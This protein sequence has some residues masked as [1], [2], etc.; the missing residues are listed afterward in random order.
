MPGIEARAYQDFQ[1][2]SFKPLD[3]V[4]QMPGF[5]KE[6]FN[7]QLRNG[8]D[9]YLAG[10]QEKSKE[11][12]AYELEQDAVLYRVLAKEKG[13]EA[14][15]EAKNGLDAY[16]KMQLETHLGERLNVGIS[17][18]T[19]RIVDGELRTEDTNEPVL[20]M[21]DRGRKYRRK[22]GKAVDWDR[23][24]AEVQGLSRIQATLTR[25][26]EEVAPGTMMLFAS[27]QGD[28][29]N[30]SIYKQD[31]Y[32]LQQKMEDGTV[33]AHRFTSGL[34]PEE[35]QNRLAGL[36]HRYL[37]EAVPTDAE[38]I[39]NPVRIDPGKFGLHTPEDVHTYMHKNH[40]HMSREKFAVVR[41]SCEPI[42][43]QYIQALT[44]EPDNRHL[45][46]KLYRALLN[47]ADNVATELKEA[48]EGRVVGLNQNYFEPVRP[49]IPPRINIDA[50][51]QQKV[52]FTDTGCG[53][54]GDASS[55]MSV[56]EFG[57][58]SE[59][60]KDKCADCGKDSKDKHYHC[61]GC[62]KKYADETSV[63]AGDRTKKC[64]CGFEFGC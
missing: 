24:A 3:M 52:R 8:R 5:N 46:E 49:L 38:F 48:Q 34:T 11:I 18:F 17:R 1:Q 23:E 35:T 22:H 45:Q 39:A 55:A 57:K 42:T 6:G 15:E 40:E 13:T 36:D 60:G 32:E 54:S 41:Q 10:E 59:P 28:V 19:Y 4:P 47:Y 63:S 20:E 51:A 44:E 64:N 9:V 53:G 12:K 27:P 14:Y 7:T 62:T 29:K 37:R 50:L 56:V 2:A 43:Q 25:P 30:G 58:N 31:F 16:I 26:D 33:I 61:P 21:I